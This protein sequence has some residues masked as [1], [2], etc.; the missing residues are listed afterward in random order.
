MGDLCPWPVH[1]EPLTA[2]PFRLRCSPR[3]RSSGGTGPPSFAK[4]PL[5]FGGP[6]VVFVEGGFAVARGP[7]DPGSAPAGA[8]VARLARYAI[9]A[10]DD[11]SSRFEPQRA[12]AGGWA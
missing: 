2:D 8:P 4:H 6:T 9:S 1:G 7:R 12:T 10:N 11:K 5:N 3:D